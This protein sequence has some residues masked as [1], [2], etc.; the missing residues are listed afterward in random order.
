MS[1]WLQMENTEL[2]RLKRLVEKTLVCSCL[3]EEGFDII[4]FGLIP[5][6]KQPLYKRNTVARVLAGLAG[7]VN[8]PLYK[9]IFSGAVF[10][11]K[12]YDKDA[13]PIFLGGAFSIVTT[14]ALLSDTLDTWNW[15]PFFSR[16]KTNVIVLN[17]I[18]IFPLQECYRIN[19]HFHYTV[20]DRITVDPLLIRRRFYVPDNT[21]WTSPSCEQSSP[22]DSL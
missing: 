9:P 2:Y 7:K 13:P 4:L 10:N 3:Y 5:S 8:D 15:Q 22:R 19:V 21:D 1:L 14:E 18:E 16:N 12:R 20:D 11:E 17:R 6:R